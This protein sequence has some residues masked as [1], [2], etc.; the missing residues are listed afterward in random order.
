MS[1]AVPSALVTVILVL[2]AF[3]ITRLI[4]WDDFPPVR[5]VRDRVLKTTVDRSMTQRQPEPVY[6]Y[7]RPILAQFVQCPYCLGFWV[8]L[9]CWLGWVVTPDV[10]YV[11]VPFALS[12]AVGIVGRMLDP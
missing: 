4:G 11:L 12:G 9:V 8:V 7:G 2:A 5:R 1:G 6:R 10:L 3:R